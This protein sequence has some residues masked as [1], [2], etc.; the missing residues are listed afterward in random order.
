VKAD[1]KQFNEL[2]ARCLA[3]ECSQEE[4]AGLR[5]V[6]SNNPDLKT[7]YELINALFGKNKNGVVPPDKK[8]FAR[9]KKRLEDEGSM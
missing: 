3:G 1:S 6:L 8:H 4:L 5:S 9:I 7:E 2:M